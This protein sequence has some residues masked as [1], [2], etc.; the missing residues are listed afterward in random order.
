MD[1]PNEIPDIPAIKTDTKSKNNFIIPILAATIFIGICFSLSGYFHFHWG[2]SDSPSGDAVPEDS[3]A[4]RDFAENVAITLRNIRYDNIQQ[5]RTD[6]VGLLSND[7][8]TPYQKYYNDS[9][10]INLVVSRKLWCKFEK[11]DRSTLDKRVGNVAAIKVIGVCTYHSDISGNEAE[12]P[13]TYLIQVEQTDGNFV[14]TKIQ[15]L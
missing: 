7:V 9:A 14:C 11:I 1:V 8:L 6:L 13:F 5:T 12:Y 2:S 15:R 3:R 4:Y 10:F